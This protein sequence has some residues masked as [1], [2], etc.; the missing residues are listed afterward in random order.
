MKG[1]SANKQEKAWMSAICELGCCVC[2][3]ELGLFSPAMPH[4][5][6]GRTKEGAHYQTIPLCFL[7]HQSGRNDP[8]CVS[9]HPYKAEFEKRYGKQAE[10]LKQVQ[11][12]INAD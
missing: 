7:H 12:L 1:K 2:R 10:L 9:V 5:L 3:N 8:E 6:S 4:H 11:G